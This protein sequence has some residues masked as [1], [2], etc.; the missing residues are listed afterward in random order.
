MRC[1][2][3]LAMVFSAR[4]ILFLTAMLGTSRPTQAVIRHV[5]LLHPS[6]PLLAVGISLGSIILTKYLGETGEQ[7][8]LIG[9][10]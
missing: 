10:M 8:G 7:S 1:H 5:G 2:G 9:A 6:A 4:I 3:A